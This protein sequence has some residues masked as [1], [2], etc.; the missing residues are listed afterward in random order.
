MEYQTIE[1]NIVLASQLNLDFIELNM[2]FLYCYP[3]Q[4]LRQKLYLQEKNMV[5]HLPF[6]LR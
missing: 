6:L 4:D 5:Y 2:N 1:E 3:S